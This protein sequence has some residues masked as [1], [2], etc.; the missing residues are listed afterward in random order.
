M[1]VSGGHPRVVVTN[2][3]SHPQIGA[4]AALD[5]A[6]LVSGRYSDIPNFAALVNKFGLSF[7]FQGESPGQRS[8]IRYDLATE[9]IDLMNTEGVVLESMD[10]S[11]T[12]RIN[13]FVERAKP[14]TLGPSV[15][16]KC[17]KFW[18]LMMSPSRGS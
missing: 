6:K 9:E 1:S 4:N 17:R 11:G 16:C 15:I 2:Q 7:L 3:V 13:I 5:G 18:L 8:Q 12:P 10:H 14:V